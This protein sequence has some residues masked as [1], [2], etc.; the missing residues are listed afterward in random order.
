MSPNTTR[1]VAALAGAAVL[2]TLAACGSSTTTSGTTPGPASEPT[3]TTA[4]PTP[5]AP[6]VTV[7][8]TISAAAEPT[9]P[10]P[11]DDEGSS[12]ASTSSSTTPPSPST[13]VPIEAEPDPTS[14][15][16]SP[17]TS[18][19][20]APSTSSDAAPESAPAPPE[21][22]APT[23][24]TAVVWGGG[25][26]GGQVPWAPLAWWDGRGWNRAG[27]DTDG[28]FV[29][30]PVPSIAN[31]SATSLD[32][33]DG[34]GQ[35]V[36]GLAL[37][38]DGAYCVDDETGPTIAG[39]AL[40]D[41]PLGV[42]YDAIAVS[43][44]WPLQPRPV[45]Q[46]GADSPEYQQIGASFVDAP[47]ADT[48][49]V[50]Q[51]VRVDLDGDGLE[52]VLV[53]YDRITEPNFGADDDFSVVYARFPELDGSVRNDV[54]ASYVLDAP[55]QFPTVGRYSLA[56]VADLNGDGVMEVA[57]RNRFW[58]SAGIAVYEYRDGTLELIASGGCGV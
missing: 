44:D 31:V 50:S 49:T 39:V 47:T 17:I 55:D 15:P 30:P 10:T 35:T 13:A 21:A 52:E 3:I 34:D 20:T 45:R 27:F 56:A 42:G 41:S 53:T 19:S 18:S 29:A 14:A 12:S 1:A 11:A 57:V 54:V 7:A 46:V 6:P 5:S 8:S 51:V 22:A 23:G 58:E 25:G 9:V 48:G 16:G 43:A 24:E 28:S 4:P 38:P 26:S 32:L 40:P 36:A 2:T 37:G 33:P